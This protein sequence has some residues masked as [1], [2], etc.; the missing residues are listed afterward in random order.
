MKK[1]NNPTC[2]I[3]GR[4]IKEGDKGT[5]SAGIELTGGRLTVFGHERCISNVRKNIFRPIA[6]DMLKTHKKGVS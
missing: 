2:D 5:Y 6:L 4:V 3:C 1:K